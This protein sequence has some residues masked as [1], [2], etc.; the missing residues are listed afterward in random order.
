[1]DRDENAALNIVGTG[2]RFS[3]KGAAGE[4]VKGNPEGGKAIPGA[5]AAQ[6]THHPKS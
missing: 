2:L 1:V 3:L 4:A 5:D 6:L